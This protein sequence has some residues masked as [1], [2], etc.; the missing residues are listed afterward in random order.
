MVAL[1]GT[2]DWPRS[3][4]CWSQGAARCSA[5]SPGPGAGRPAFVSRL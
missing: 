2:A 1:A 5:S 4:R 3:L